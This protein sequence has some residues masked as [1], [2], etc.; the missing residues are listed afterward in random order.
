M[1]TARTKAFKAVLKVGRFLRTTVDEQNYQQKRRSLDKLERFFKP[2]K[3]TRIEAI[4][5]N[6]FKGE[7]LVG[8]QVS[9]DRVVLYM[10][11]GGF[12]FYPKLYRNMIARIGQASRARVFSLD[13]SLA[14]EHPYPKPLH[15]AAAAYQWLLTSYKPEQIAIAGDSAGGTLVLTLLHHIRNNHLPQPACAVTLSPATD[16]TFSGPSFEANIDK[17]FFIKRE[18][19][20]FF[21]RAY[22]AD[23]PYN[24]PIASPYHGELH[25]FPPLL[26]HIDNDEIM[27][28]DTSQFAQKARAAQTEVEVYQTSGMWHVFHLYARYVPEAREAIQNI[29]EF[30]QKRA[31][32]QKHN[33]IAK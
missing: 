19:L 23:T 25:G 27:F 22:F 1:V 32:G 24:D 30:I 31:S 16:A 8:K 10:H 26:M 28:D 33:N 29:G 5:Q 20:E 9:E 18:S 6:G 3:S 2:P 21:V 7:W 17:D 11:G 4:T 14:P 13:Y 12:V 15:E